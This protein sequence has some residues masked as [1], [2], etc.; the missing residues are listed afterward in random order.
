MVCDITSCCIVDHKAHGICC[1]SLLQYLDL[2][3]SLPD[4]NAVVFPHCKCDAR[5]VGHVIV[6]ISRSHIRLKA[7]TED[8]AL[9]EQ[10][11]T[12]A[13]DMVVQHEADMEEEAFTF[14]YNREGKSPRW[15]RVYSKYVSGHVGGMR[16][17]EIPL[18]MGCVLYILYSHAYRDIGGYKLY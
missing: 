10:E 15:V 18:G 6:A 7:C 12:F 11:H 14:Q 9:E 4:S 5:K 17:M 8:G 1:C 2:V 13:W 3:R 16:D